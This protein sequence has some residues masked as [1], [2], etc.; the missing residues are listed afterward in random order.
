L[1][2]HTEQQQRFKTQ[3]KIV[4]KVQTHPPSPNSHTTYNETLIFP[5]SFLAGLMGKVKKL[6]FLKRGNSKQYK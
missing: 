3:K 2:K 4:F 6:F 5:L 1:T